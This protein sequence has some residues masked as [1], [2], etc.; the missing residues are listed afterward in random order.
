M[1]V[2]WWYRVYMRVR[3]FLHLLWQGW[4]VRRVI[5]QRWGGP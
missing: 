5:R 3:I 1:E 2:F 4:A